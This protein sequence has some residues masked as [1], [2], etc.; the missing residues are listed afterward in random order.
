LL[1]TISF[2]WVVKASRK[3]EPHVGRQKLK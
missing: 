1:L 3:I 2:F